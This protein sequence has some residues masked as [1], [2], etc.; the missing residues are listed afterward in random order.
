MADDS[1]RA[2][3]ARRPRGLAAADAGYV[4]PPDE[5]TELE[6]RVVAWSR[7][8]EASECMSQSQHDQLTR[9]NKAA[10]TA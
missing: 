1:L 10:A 7:S 6:R 3:M 2:K 5:L 9:W 4:V 8:G